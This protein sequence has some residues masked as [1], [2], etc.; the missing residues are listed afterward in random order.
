M[1]ECN[2]IT[3]F[4]LPIWGLPNSDWDICRDSSTERCTLGDSKGPNG[5][6]GGYTE[7]FKWPAFDKDELKRDLSIVGLSLA[8][9]AAS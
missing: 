2:L 4:R 1:R 6:D 3:H 5:M 9:G 7:L 8:K